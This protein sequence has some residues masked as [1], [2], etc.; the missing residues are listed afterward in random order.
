MSLASGQRRTALAALGRD[1]LVALA[2]QFGRA[3]IRVKVRR[4]LTKYGYSPDKR[5]RVVETVI[6]QAELLAAGWAA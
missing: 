2:D 1:P 5:E 3:Q 6:K 4:L